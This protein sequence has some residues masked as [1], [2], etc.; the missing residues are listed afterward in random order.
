[1]MLR[2][3]C[4]SSWCETL[5]GQDFDNLAIPSGCSAE[6]SASR[7]LKAAAP[8]APLPHSKALVP[9]PKWSL[10]DD[11]AYNF[12]AVAYGRRLTDACP[13]AAKWGARNRARFSAKCFRSYDGE[14]MVRIIP[15]WQ[16]KSFLICN[17]LQRFY[18]Y[19]G[20]STLMTTWGSR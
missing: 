10:C 4:E 1:M 3:G 15:M 20:N 6:L 8:R 13:R 7:S 9:F 5:A 16:G 17:F 14:T 11:P 19:L 2:R 12:R 18:V